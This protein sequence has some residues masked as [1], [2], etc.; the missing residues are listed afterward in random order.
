MN[1]NA[2]SAIVCVL[3]VLTFGTCGLFLANV[4]T[5]ASI[6]IKV[7]GGGTSNV[8]VTGAD[9]V[10]VNGTTSAVTG[11][12]FTVTPTW[13]VTGEMVAVDV[14]SNAGAASKLARVDHKHQAVKSVAGTNGIT[15]NGTSGSSQSGTVSVSPTYGVIANTVSEGNHVHG[16]SD[17]TNAGF[18]P[19][20]AGTGGQFYRDD[21]TW[22]AIP[23]ASSAGATFFYDDAAHASIG[24][25]FKL[26]KAPNTTAEATDTSGALTANVTLTIENYAST[27]L[28][29]TAVPGGAWAFH[30]WALCNSTAAGSVT[31]LVYEVYSRTS[32]G[33]ETLLFYDQTPALTTSFTEYVTSSVRPAYV[34]NTTDFLVIRVRAISTNT[35][36]TASFTHNGTARYSNVETPFGVFSTAPISYDVTNG[37]SLTYNSTYMKTTGTYLDLNIAASAQALGTAQAAG[38]A[39]SVSNGGHVHAAPTVG[40]DGTAGS[41]TTSLIVNSDSGNTTVTSSAVGGTTN[42]TVVAW[43]PNPVINGAMQVDQRTAGASKELAAATGYALDRWFCAATTTTGN[44][45]QLSA[46]APAGI[47]NYLR[48]QHKS[49][50]ATNGG[51]EAYQALESK[52]SIPYQSSTVTLSLRARSGRVDHGFNR[53]NFGLTASDGTDQSSA[54]LRGGAWAHRINTGIAATI[55]TSWQTFTVTANVSSTATQLGVYAYVDATGTADGTDYVD[56]TDVRL[57]RGYAPAPYIWEYESELRRCQRYGF[58]VGTGTNIPCGVGIVTGSTYG[59]VTVQHPVPMRGNASL[60]FPGSAITEWSARKSDSSLL[61]LNTLSVSIGNDLATVLYFDCGAGVTAGNATNLISNAA[62]SKLFLSSEL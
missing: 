19:I 28:G 58:A 10:T 30:T 46:G 48:A 7:P 9:G 47:P 59:V 26:L 1:R 33:V 42:V 27:P 2:R 21:G 54:N 29:Q 35:S 6:E 60:S 36:R 40:I 50:D 32:G 8:T 16:V 15:V 44:F 20:L 22:A 12:S 4:S 55:T 53:L 31:R 56:I 43:E 37:V 17:I 52:H 61:A 62:T 34:V 13:G 14:S 38:S 18:A 3:I 23:I 11:N 24:G 5:G 39:S 51:I 25:Y 41:A 45:Q 57:N 49:G